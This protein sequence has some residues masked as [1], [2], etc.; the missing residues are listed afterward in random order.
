MAVDGFLK[1]E[2]ALI[3]LK[4]GEGGFGMDKHA[5]FK[6]SYGVYIV[7]SVMDGKYNG[8]IANTVF[9]VAAEPPLMAVCINRQNLSHDF[10]SSSRVAA[11]SVLAENAPM[12]TIGLFGFKSGR[13][14]N[15]LEKVN[16]TPGVTGAPIV[17]DH[18]VAFFEMK[19]T[20]AIECATHTIFVGEVVEA[21][22]LSEDHPM[23]YAFYRQVKGGKSPKAAPTYIKE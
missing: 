21:G 14:V 11:V 8:Q 5:F 19:I 20:Q 23:T 17:L 6:L 2:N 4:T 9:Q 22:I 16:F 12:T 13:E 18:S 15:K 3:S 7:T 10:I 1:A